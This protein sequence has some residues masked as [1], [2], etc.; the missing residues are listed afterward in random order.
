M[1][2]ELKKLAAECRHKFMFSKKIKG[3]YIGPKGEFIPVPTGVRRNGRDYANA[4]GGWRISIRSKHKTEI[5]IDV[6]DY[7]FHHDYKASLQEAIR[8]LSTFRPEGL[9]K[10]LK[11]HTEKERSHKKIKLGISGVR[12]ETLD[13]KGRR[14]Y[15]FTVTC[16]KT[17]RRVPV[18]RNYTQAEFDAGLE[19]AKTMR[20]EFERNKMEKNRFTADLK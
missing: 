9:L 15:Y 18:P 13:C 10:S 3:G 2:K 7:C 1:D 12:F 20:Q 17:Q 16:G 5:Q 11:L 8:Q 14:Y 6:R 19:K 4:N